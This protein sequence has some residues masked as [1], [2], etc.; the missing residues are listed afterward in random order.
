MRLTIVIACT[1]LGTATQLAA[2][3][4]AYFG[5]GPEAASHLDEI[6]AALRK[7]W[8][9]RDTMDW[10]SFRKRVYARAGRAQTIP[11]TYDA[12]RLALTLLGDQHS[13]YTTSD[14]HSIWNPQS[15]TQSTH[16]CTPMAFSIPQIPPGIGY[17][18]V[19]I[20]PQTPT[21]EIQTVLREGAQKGITR[22]VVDLR[23]SRGGNMWP[24]LAGI[25]P[26]LGDG[27]AGYFVE[28][29]GHAMPWGYRH[30]LAWADSNSGVRADN[31]AVFSTNVR[32][33]VLTDI[34]VASS[35]E[36]ITIAFRARPN[37]RS[38]GTPT[39]G[40]STAI[41]GVRLKNGASINFVGAVMADRIKRQYGKSITP[42]EVI[43]DPEQTVFRAVQWLVRS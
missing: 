4:K 10:E 22:W 11:D 16:R 12:I 34:G 19:R 9:Y 5:V 29:G 35:G 2:L 24:A 31:P 30:G 32:V 15:P 25:G 18:R 1:C 39:C 3:Q 36:A 43:A 23:N 26:L 33:A 21:A 40:L 42:D 7:G 38:F 20:T 8:L 28:A 17:V 37:V 13:H 6:V 41:G 14:G 27:V